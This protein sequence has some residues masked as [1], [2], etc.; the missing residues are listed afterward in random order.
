MK[1]LPEMCGEKYFSDYFFF[2]LNT[3]QDSVED[4]IQR[5]ARYEAKPKGKLTCCAFYFSQGRTPNCLTTGGSTR[6]FQSEKS[7]FK[8]M[9]VAHDMKFIEES[10]ALLERRKLGIP[11]PVYRGAKIVEDDGKEND[12]EDDEEPKDQDHLKDEAENWEDDEE[13][14]ENYEYDSYWLDDKLVSKEEFEAGKINAKKS[15]KK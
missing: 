8:H 13:Y 10:K 2:H 5:S 14:D 1:R 3:M 9:L 15:V 6:G 7:L 11:D 4:L 12:L